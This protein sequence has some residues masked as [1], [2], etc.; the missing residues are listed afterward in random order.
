MDSFLIENNQ[1]DLVDN[2]N[3]SIN[4]TN[5]NDNSKHMNDF[6]IN[7]MNSKYDENENQNKISNKKKTKFI[8]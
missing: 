2:N 6:I 4:N 1:L 7:S 3:N 8:L 5:N